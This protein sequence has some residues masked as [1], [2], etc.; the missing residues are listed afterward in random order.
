MNT[1]NVLYQKINIP[2]DGEMYLLVQ[3]H[4]GCPGQSPESH[5]MVVCVNTFNAIWFQ[6]QYALLSCV[7]FLLTPKIT[8]DIVLQ[9]RSYFWHTLHM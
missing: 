7:Y 3:A 9:S 5:K 4:P 6:S 1:F 2:E 8:T